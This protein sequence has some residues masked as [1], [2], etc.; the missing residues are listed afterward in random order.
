MRLRVEAK[1]LKAIRRAEYGLPGLNAAVA[2]RRRR[3]T[4]LTE[5]LCQLAV[6]SNEKRA[7]RGFLATLLWQ[8]PGVED[9]CISMIRLV[10]R[11]EIPTAEEEMIAI[12][13]IDAAACIE[14]S[15]GP[16]SADRDYWSN[17]LAS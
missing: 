2:R 17:V 16:A 9:V 11:I 3:S 10:A 4:P 14:G 12:D 6:D 1:L 13:A 7:H 5:T 8:T 15:A